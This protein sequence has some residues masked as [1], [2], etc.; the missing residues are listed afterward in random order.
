MDK[1]ISSKNDY[2]I[3]EK[4]KTIDININNEKWQEKLKDGNYT[5]YND[6]DKCIDLFDVT[7]IENITE[8]I[9]YEKLETKEKRIIPAINELNKK[10]R[11]SK[12]KEVGTREKNK[13]HENWQI[14]YDFQ[15][16]KHYRVYYSW[17][18]YNPVYSIQEFIITI[19]TKKL[20]YVNIQTFNN[21][22]D[23]VIL[24]IQNGEWI[25]TYT[26]KGVLKGNVWKLEELQ[27]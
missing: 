2:K 26:G 1:I 6:K 5:Q 25:T 18:I 24:L 8:H 11:G 22:I 23:I 7:L 17:D 14:T 10:Q 27:E 16:N 9:N 15:E 19:N 20:D 12:W 3:E 4:D 21:N 13:W